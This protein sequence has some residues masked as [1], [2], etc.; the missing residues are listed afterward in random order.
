MDSLLPR[1]WKVENCGV[2]EKRPLSTPLTTKKFPN[3]A[4]PI[5][6]AMLPDH[7]PNEPQDVST[8]PNG[9]VAK[10]RSH[11]RIDNQARLIAKLRARGSGDQL[12]GLKRIGWNL[13]GEDLVLLVADGLSVK[14]VTHL[15]VISQRMKEAVGVR[16][17][18]AA[19][20]GNRLTQLCSPDRRP[21]V[22]GRRSG[23][24]PGAWRDRFPPCAADAVTLSA[25]DFAR[26]SS[27]MSATMG[28]ELR[29]SIVRLAGAKPGA[30]AV[31]R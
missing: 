11:R 17:D 3:L 25:V 6:N 21:A 24:R 23:P 4:V 12:H 5:P 8:L 7:V 15:R 2:S 14:H 28:R 30:S 31:S 16:G 18:T 29:T 20:G 1:P 26:R 10:A 27:E 22:S 19:T 13:R 9:F